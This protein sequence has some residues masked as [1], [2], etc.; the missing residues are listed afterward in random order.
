M[1][2]DQGNDLIFDS[3]TRPRISKRSLIL[4]SENPLVTFKTKSPMPSLDIRVLNKVRDF[5]SISENN[6]NYELKLDRKLTKKFRKRKFLNLR[7]EIENIYRKSTRNL[8]LA[9]GSSLKGRTFEIF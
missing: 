6:G 7:L 2:F 9:P 4:P 3:A 5:M 1:R 8:G